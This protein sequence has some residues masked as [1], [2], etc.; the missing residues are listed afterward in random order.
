MKESKKG[1]RMTSKERYQTYKALYKAYYQK[2]RERLLARQKE[3]RLENIEKIRELHK[4]EKYK[5][6]RKNWVKRN[7][8]KVREYQYRYYREVVKPK[9]EALSKPERHRL[10]EL[11]G[12]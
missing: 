4:S 3:Y 10:D 8:K 1:P 9:N 2:N 6:Y 11:F 12:V 7:K 5:E